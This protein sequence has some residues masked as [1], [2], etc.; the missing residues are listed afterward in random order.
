MLPL[1]ALELLLLFAG[2][3]SSPQAAR[4]IGERSGGAGAPHHLQ[5]AL[6]RRVV[7][8]Q[9]LHRCVF[10]GMGSSRF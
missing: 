9:F 7:A 3:S 6:A 8:H 4:K 10:V 1:L 5:E 2:L